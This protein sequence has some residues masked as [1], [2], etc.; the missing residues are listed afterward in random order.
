MRAKTIDSLKGSTDTIEVTEGFTRNV[1]LN[2]IGNQVFS[3]DFE[4]PGNYK[5]ISVPVTYPYVWTTS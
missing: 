1:A 5:A 2:C 4:H 3:A